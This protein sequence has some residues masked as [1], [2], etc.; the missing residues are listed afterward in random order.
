MLQRA[1]N[2]Y[3]SSAWVSKSKIWKNKVG[4]VYIFMLGVWPFGLF[5]SYW[6]E[7]GI[8]VYRYLFFLI[9][10]YACMPVVRVVEK[11]LP[12]VL[13]LCP[14]N[15]AEKIKYMKCAIMVQII[16]PIMIG[17]VSISIA[18][19]LCDDRWNLQI[20]LASSMCIASIGIGKNA[21]PSNASNSAK[22]YKYREVAVAVVLIIIAIKNMIPFACGLVDSYIGIRKWRYV[23][24]FLLMLGLDIWA[25]RKMIPREVERCVVYAQENGK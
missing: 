2:D 23:I 20:M 14:M 19:L 17:L 21:F 8:D 22:I 18:M 6:C 15:K 11:G 5:A 4:V 3:V 16:A 24:S 13:Q 7:M 10:L 12:K 9:P 25:I 1:I